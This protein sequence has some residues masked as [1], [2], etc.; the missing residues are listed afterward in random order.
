MSN[1]NLISD[2]FGDGEDPAR[3]DPVRSARAAQKRD[4]PKRFYTAVSTELRD[5]QHVLLLDGRPARTKQR[6]LLGATTPAAAAML[7]D[8]WAGQETHINPATMPTTRILHAAID[9][10]AE[11][12]DAVVADI[13][14]YAGS[15]LVCYRAGEPEKLVALESAHWDPVLDH[16]RIRHGARFR[17]AEGIGFVEQPREAIAAVAQALQPYRAPA[18]LA[19]LHVLTTISGSAL[20][21]LAVADGA[22]TPDAGFAA[23]EVDADFEISLWGSDEEAA[24]FRAARE[25]DFLAAAALLAALGRDFSRG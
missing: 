25:R 15:D 22:V 6:N 5:G 16:A 23:G 17:L 21:A 19:A 12:G 13:L 11:A 24:S 8:E 1:D 10:V 7:A 2:W 20:V 9:H 14:K 3:Y 18:M 4:L